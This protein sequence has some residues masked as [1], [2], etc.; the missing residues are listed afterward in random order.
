MLHKHDVSCCLPSGQGDHVPSR[1][2]NTNKSKH[3][4]WC[5]EPCGYMLSGSVWIYGIRSRVDIWCQEPCWYMVSWA[6]WIYVPSDVWIYGVIRR[7]DIWCH[8][9]CGYMVSWGVWIYGV[10]I[11]VDI[12]C[13]EMCRCMMPWDVWINGVRRR[14]D[15]FNVQIVCLFLPRMAT[16][17]TTQSIWDPVRKRRKFVC[18]SFCSSIVN[19]C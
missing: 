16:R 3:P 8:Q 5:Q 18:L 17:T 4:V 13:H 19:P 1:A 14:V 15:T 7:V 9:K 2:S 10:M 12:W 11:R 6:V